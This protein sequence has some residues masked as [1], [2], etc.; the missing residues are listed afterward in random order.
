MEV[1]KDKK[2]LKKAFRESSIFNH[3]YASVL[4]A[5]KTIMM[6]ELIKRK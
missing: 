1:F 5:E 4:G 6:R 2:K 3:K